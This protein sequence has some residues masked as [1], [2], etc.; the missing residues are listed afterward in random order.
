MRRSLLMIL[1]GALLLAAPAAR[2]DWR[3][4][5][6]VLN[7]GVLATGGA[8]YRIASLQPFR[9]YLEARIG[10][11]VNIV[12]AASWGELIDAETSGR[13]QYA[14]LSAAAYAEALSTCH[15]VEVIAA[16]KA[17]DG[18]L[19]YHSVLVVKADS[20]IKALADARGA[21]L[22]LAGED[23]VAGRLIPMQSFAHEGIAPATYFSKI[24]EVANPEAAIGA[25]LDGTVDIAAGWSSLTGEAESG[26]DFGLLASMTASGKLTPGEVRVVW[27]SPLIPF[28]PHVVRSDMPAEL[29]TLLAQALL[30]MADED[31]DA[32]DS[33]D[34]IGY[35]GGG[36]AAPDAALYA[37]I[38]ELVAIPV[39]APAPGGPVA[40][41]AQTD[42]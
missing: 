6:G 10:L 34:R 8:S 28:G 18:A 35:G 15:C 21:K 30:D 26:Y 3:D 41:P 36:F 20:P 38:T 24:V 4:D 31:Q 19:G 11:T 12:P 13:V 29:K 16:P 7:V 22:A 2:A 9:A 5:M 32:L 27:Q 33:I 14:I 37:P 23:S 1:A 17:A 42:Q 40:V 39:A 25:L